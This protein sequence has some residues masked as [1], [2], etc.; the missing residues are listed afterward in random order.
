MIY[1][2]ILP[3][4]LLTCCPKNCCPLRQVIVLHTVESSKWYVYHA[5]ARSK[6]TYALPT[7]VEICSKTG[8]NHE[9]P[10]TL[11]ELHLSNWTMAERLSSKRR[12]ILTQDLNENRPCYKW[13]ICNRIGLWMFHC[14]ASQRGPEPKFDR[15]QQSHTLIKS[16]WQL[17]KPTPPTNVQIN[18][19]GHAKILARDHFALPN[20]TSL[21]ESTHNA[22]SRTLPQTPTTSIHIQQK[23]ASLFPFI[24]QM[25]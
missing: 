14:R 19:E 22:Q 17:N 25:I 16:V 21:I 2:G 1:P 18:R 5:K 7:Q 11:N 9:Q 10:S 15:A 8:L 23:S 3:R 12:C 13:I 20:I 24:H 4:T 6:I